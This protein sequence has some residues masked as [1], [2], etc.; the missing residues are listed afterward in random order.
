MFGG[1][2]LYVCDFSGG[3]CVHSM[4]CVLLPLYMFF[5]DIEISIEKALESKAVSN[6][7]SGILL[8]NRI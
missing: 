2:I 1:D 8:I 3:V 4:V 7:F 5:I 6:F